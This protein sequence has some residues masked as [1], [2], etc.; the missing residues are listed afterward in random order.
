MLLVWFGFHV[1]YNFVGIVTSCKFVFIPSQNFTALNNHQT[2]NINRYSRIKNPCILYVLC[3]VKKKV[4]RSEPNMVFNP[5]GVEAT[6]LR[7]MNPFQVSPIFSKFWW[8]SSFDL[9]YERSCKFQ[10]KTGDPRNEKSRCKQYYGFFCYFN[11][12]PNLIV[13]KY[14]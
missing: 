8:V 5:R 9:I 6:I 12:P 4:H 1:L 3:I 7:S 10:M 11:R 14:Y 13:I 2:D